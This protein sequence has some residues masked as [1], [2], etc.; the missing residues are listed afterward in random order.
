VIEVDVASNKNEM[1]EVEDNRHKIG[2]MEINMNVE[3]NE[4]KE[5]EDEMMK[6]E[7]NRLEIEE[8]EEEENNCLLKYV[9][10]IH[11]LKVTWKMSLKQYTEF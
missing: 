8:M 2:K 7:N 10:M 11:V 3:T 1:I 6:V 4:P 5:N 9:Q